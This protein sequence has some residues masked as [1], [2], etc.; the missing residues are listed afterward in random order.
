MSGMM[1]AQ[2]G[3][4][5]PVFLTVAVNDIAGGVV[6]ALA[7]C[8]GVLDRVRHGAGQ[9][10]WSSLAA[11]SVFMQSGELVR[12]EG[13]PR[14]R[15]GGNDHRGPSPLD[16]YHRTSDGWVRVQ[17]TPAQVRALTPADLADGVGALLRADASPRGT[18]DITSHFSTREVLD[19]LSKRG[20]PAVA[21]RRPAELIG[22]ARLMAAGA[23]HEHRRADGRPFFTPGRVARFSRTQQ[24]GTLVPPGLGEH[25]REVLR[26]AGLGAAEVDAL[27]AE[28]AVASGKPFVVT[29]LLA[30]R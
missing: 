24:T 19:W 30:Y 11:M 23:F 17:A 9:P 16:R 22:D 27:L 14:A 1:K 20:I 4:D 5:D 8:L 7:T 29:E 21:A 26:H 15:I 28:G 6:G 25:T 13:R 2:G 18:A 10:S 3:A 12:F